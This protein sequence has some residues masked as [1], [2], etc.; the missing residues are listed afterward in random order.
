MAESF[1]GRDGDGV[2]RWQQASDECAE[3]EEHGGC[4]QTACGKG[5]LHPVGE[6]Y[7]KKTVKAKTYDDAHCCAD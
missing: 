5:T 2:A 3:S 6:D 7:A 1:G 4:Q